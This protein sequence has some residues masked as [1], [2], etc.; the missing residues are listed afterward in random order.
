MQSRRCILQV[1][2]I[3]LTISISG[4]ASQNGGDYVSTRIQK[5]IEAD[6]LVGTDDFLYAMD[7]RVICIDWE[8]NTLWE[9][10]L[11]G[12]RGMIYLGDSFFAITF[13]KSRTEWGIA[14]LNDKGDVLWQKE[15]G[16]ISSIG[17]GA[18]QDLLAV[19][20][21]RTGTLSAFSRTGD[22]LWVYDHSSRINQVT[23]SSDGS[24]VVFTDD[25]NAVDCVRDG[26]LIWSHDVGSIDIGWK[27]TIAI[28]PDNS[29]CVYGSEK[30]GPQIVAATLDGGVLWSHPVREYLLSVAISGD[31]QYIVCGA[32]ENVYKF[33]RDGTKMWASGIGGNNDYI[34][35]TPSADV[36][37]V[38]SNGLPA[39]LVVLN[40][41]GE[42]LWEARSFDT[43][44]S[45]G[46]SPNG[47]Y[48]AFSNRLSQ[49]FIF[50]N[51]PEPNDSDVSLH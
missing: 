21:S 2:I 25:D 7:A 17:I 20:S 10:P 33:T 44:F 37:A 3:C 27:R 50:A 51:P 1:I 11:L 15:I 14:Y 46:I 35:L 45:V 42:V 22:V 19:G 49:L 8:G 28:A 18:S 29:Y 30:G 26:N 6:V 31:S 40:G 24:Y 13:D 41:D 9:S 39:T 43:I 4:C 23:V 16:G 34:A 36:I 38:G 5:D 47:K 12:G 48:V 32:F